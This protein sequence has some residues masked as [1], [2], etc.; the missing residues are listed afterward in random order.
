MIIQ[1]FENTPPQQGNILPSNDD[2]LK[3]VKS[4][5]S[6]NGASGEMM[7]EQNG[8]VRPNVDMRYYHN[9]QWIKVEEQ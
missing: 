6:W 9:G 5:K 7:I 1:A 2:V 4:H 3:T 8:I